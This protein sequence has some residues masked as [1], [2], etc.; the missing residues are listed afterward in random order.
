MGGP[1]MIDP[2]SDTV[3]ITGAAGLIGG[4]LRVGLRPAWRKLRLLDIQPI[5]DPH[6]NE[7]VFA[8]DI[9][10]RAALDRAMSGAAALVHLAGVHDPY[11]LED[12]F[13]VNARGM[14]DAFESAR[15]AGVRRIVFASSNHAHGCYPIGHLVTPADPPRPDSLYG[16]FK[17]W[18]ETM[19]RTYH[20][21]HGISS[22][23]LR[24]GTFRPEPID[25]RSLATWLSPADIVQLVHLAL[26]NPDP[27]AMVVNAYSGNKH[28]KVSTEGWD[29]LGYIPADNAE[30]FREQLR[31]KGVDV[32]GS[33]EWEEHGGSMAREP[34]HPPR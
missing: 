17:A 29:R 8:A 12:L 16:T 9:A 25:Q 1:G 18:G 14:F 33:W 15:L 2:E 19:L 32:D 23:S 22:V 7:T 4:F 6:A 11:T 3:V 28:L 10:D 34:E 24:I 5:A 27:G 20:D 26:R 13:A 21:R 31:A 30:T